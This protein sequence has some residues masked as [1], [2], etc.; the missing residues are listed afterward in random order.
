M[1]LFDTYFVWFGQ[2][3]AVLG[4][5]TSVISHRCK[6]QNHNRTKALLRTVTLKWKQTTDYECTHEMELFDT[7]FV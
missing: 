4:M 3:L 6:W 5:K 1:E 7:N 2:V